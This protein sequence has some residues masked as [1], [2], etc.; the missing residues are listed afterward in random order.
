MNTEFFRA[1]VLDDLIDQ[2]SLGEMSRAVELWQ[3]RSAALGKCSHACGKQVVA[4][5]TLA[6]GHCLAQKLAFE[7]EL[8]NNGQYGACSVQLLNW[9]KGAAVRA[10]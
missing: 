1:F 4:S 6:C 10:S 7:H 3:E 9:L 2:I 5:D 8:K